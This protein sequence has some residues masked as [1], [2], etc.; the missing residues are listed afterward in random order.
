MSERT[1][2]AAS[3]ETAGPTPRKTDRHEMDDPASPP[4]RTVPPQQA[5]NEEFRPDSP[6]GETLEPLDA[7][8]LRQQFDFR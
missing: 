4:A 3:V 8:L 6:L 2:P 7:N 5:N 1:N